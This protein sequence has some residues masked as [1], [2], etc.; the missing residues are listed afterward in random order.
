MKLC[1]AT[2]L[3]IQP[4]LKTR[5][6]GMHIENSSSPVLSSLKEYVYKYP[7]SLLPSVSMSATFFSREQ[8]SIQTY[9][10]LYYL[11]VW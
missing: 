5:L 4:I 1:D 10:Q 3:K 8:I 2:Y 6:L 9:L 7:P 11:L